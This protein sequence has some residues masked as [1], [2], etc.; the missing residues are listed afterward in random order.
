MNNRQTK[1]LEKINLLYS[2]LSREDERENESVSIEN[3]KQMLQDYAERNGLKPYKHLCDDGY[4]GANFERPGWEQLIELVED[5]CVST[6]ILKDLSRMGRD[7]LRVGLYREM[8]R[9]KNVRLIAINDGF[10]SEKGDDEFTPFKEIMAEWVARDT[11]RKVKSAL[12]TKGKSGKPLCHTPIFGYIKDPEDKH[13]RIIDPE[14]AE[15]V[16]KIFRM[17]AS[18]NGP[19]TIARTLM[20]ENIERPTNYMVSRGI[21][22]VTPRYN[23]SIPY[24][25]RGSTIV[26]LL[27]KREYIG[28]I[29]NFKTYKP[30]YKSKKFYK[31]PEE[32]HLVFENAMPAIID[33][34][35]WELAQKCRRTVRKPNRSGEVNPLTG[36]IFCADCG[37]KMTNRR[38][39]YRE[40]ENGNGYFKIDSYECAKNRLAA[41]KYIKECSLHRVN[42]V[43]IRELILDTIKTVSAYVR[44]NEAEFIERIR[45]ATTTKQIES[46]KA[47]KRQFNKNDRRISELDM[48]F[49]KVY[50]DNATGKISD[51]RFRQLADGYEIEQANL[52]EQNAQLKM[53]I[54]AFE[55]YSAGVE[56][57]IELAN[58][59]TNIDELNT[60]M[61]YEF[62]DKVVVY[63]ADRSTGERRQRLDIHLNFIGN[64]M[65][66]EM[67]REPTP[68]EIEAEE[69]RLAEKR[70]KQQNCRDYRARKKFKQELLEMENAK[71][72]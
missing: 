66:P 15:V 37:S 12:H 60:E 72:A 41:T 39:T 21:M 14:A 16:R 50:E 38:N 46:I 51:E 8:F 5:G 20:E 2:R 63:E 29:V 68:D 62:V 1:G 24:A 43:A 58:R 7:Y 45:E 42:S 53:E 31:N 49:R 57:F 36:L 64:F 11:S 33:R 34:E 4:S 10:D 25:W 22:A 27:Q 69:K 56:N 18:G 26:Q 3:Q 17:A 32:K 13:K 47:H 54:K 6:I 9:D 70:R 44:E 61:L 19:I 59:Y 48:L 55:E 35:T 23:A 71:P 30:S 40:D 67:E 28:D 65:T 52:K